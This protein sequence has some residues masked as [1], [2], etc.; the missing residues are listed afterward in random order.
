MLGRSGWRCPAVM[1]SAWRWGQ[2]ACSRATRAR[3][4]RNQPPSYTA[5]KPRRNP[6]AMTITGLA[7]SCD[8]RLFVP[9]L[10][11]RDKD[12]ALAELADHLVASGRVRAREVILH[13]I[14][15]RERI[16]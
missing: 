13:T 15:E 9:Q 12:E 8:E 1:Q 5:Q 7:A 11:A 3:L 14:R 16:W 6:G 4:T 2:A 10:R